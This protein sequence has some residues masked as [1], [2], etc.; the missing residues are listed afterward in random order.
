MKHPRTSLASF[1]DHYLSLL[2]F[3]ADVVAAL[4][5]GDIN[6]FEAEQLARLTRERLGLP[7]AQAKRRVLRCSPCTYKPKRR[8][9]GYDCE[10]NEL[11]RASA[12]EAREPAA[13]TE[14]EILEDFA[15]YDP[16]HLFWEQV[17]QLGFAFREICR[18]DITDEEIEELLRVCEPITTILS[19]RR[20]KE[21]THVVKLQ[22]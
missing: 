19:S 10:I 20:R 18:E 21:Q 9:R 15:P 16:T 1:V 5:A 17:K 8:A 3:P 11:L 2:T 6:L 13:E 4:T 12:V 22:L 14:V 7:P